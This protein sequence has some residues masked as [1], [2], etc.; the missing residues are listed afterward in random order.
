[1]KT[2]AIA[3]ASLF[4]A[5]APGA[6]AQNYY[7]NNYRDNYRYDRSRDAARVI[8]SRPVYDA[9]NSKEECWNPRA[10]HFEERRATRDS[11]VNG[12]V[13]GALAGGVIGHQIDQ[14]GG[15]V[16]GAILGGILGNQIDRQHNSNPQD[17]L[18]LSRCRVISSGSGDLQGYDVRY[19]YGGREYTTRMSRDPGRRLVLGDDVRS[20]G[21]PYDSVASYSTPSYSW[22]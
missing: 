11:N 22:R 18:D 2:V 10:G 14:G 13:V 3:V 5:L 20:D 4:T 6:F 8:E 1:M 15:T 9:A 12:T 19:E 16:A 17:D 7:G 21:T